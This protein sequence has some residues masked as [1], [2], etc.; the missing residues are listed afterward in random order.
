MSVDR[1]PFLVLPL[2]YFYLPKSARVYL[3]P[4]SV[5][6]HYLCSGPISVDPILSAAQVGDPHGRLAT[7]H[8]LP[9][10]MGLSGVHKEGV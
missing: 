3:L 2:T 8:V 1:G 4:Q 5:K 10:G 6:S 9:E 7:P